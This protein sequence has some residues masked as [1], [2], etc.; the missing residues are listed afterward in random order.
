MPVS[1][2]YIH[3]TKYLF[4]VLFLLLVCVFSCATTNES[5]VQDTATVPQ[6]P[7]EVIEDVPPARSNGISLENMKDDDVVV[8]FDTI[9][10][11]KQA[12]IT[13]K[14]EI[15]IVVD[16][17]NKITLDGTIPA[18]SGIHP[19]NTVMF[20]RVVTFSIR[21]RRV[22][23]QGRPASHPAGLLQLCVCAFTPEHARR[24]YPVRIPYPC[25]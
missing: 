7:E 21:Y 13:T 9:A 1:E 12:F 23:Y 18:G 6:P 11:T 24:R 5:V 17:L 15:E 4:P 25:T 10:I 2:Y 8:R 16:D 19:K 22:S 20:S 14:S 3:M